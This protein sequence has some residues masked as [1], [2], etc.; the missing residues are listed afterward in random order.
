MFEQ[1]AKL[2]AGELIATAHGNTLENLISNPSLSDL[3]GGT[4][5]VTLGDVEARRRRSQKTVIERKQRPTFNVIVE[6]NDWNN[7][8]VHRN[9]AATVDDILRG[10]ATRPELRWL[11]NDGGL[12]QENGSSESGDNGEPSE[13]G[14]DDRPGDS[15]IQPE[16]ESP[17]PE[18]EP[19][20]TRVVAFG[21]PRPL[22]EEEATRLNA[23]VEM[24]KDLD[25]ADMLVTTKSHYNRRPRAVRTAE[26]NG[27]TVY[28]LRKQSRE[29][30]RQFLRGFTRSLTGDEE[31]PTPTSR[32]SRRGSHQNGQRTAMQ[33]TEVAIRRVQAGEFTVELTPQTAFVRRLQHSLAGRS[34]V[35]SS[36]VGAEPERRVVL[37]RRQS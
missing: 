34:N 5:A 33:E 27:M 21:I 36:S 28:V 22:M 37:R 19:E 4:Q 15:R 6:I 7:V 16:A 32:G 35:G 1:F 13:R 2:T 9:T 30:V 20:I 29:Q 12:R 10:Y 8:G 24:V 14:Q 23:A 3:I 17:E 25:D 31:T 18:R 26:E 11:G